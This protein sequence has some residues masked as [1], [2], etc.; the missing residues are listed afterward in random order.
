M[1]ILSWGK[2]RIFLGKRGTSDE[3]P[4]SWIEVPTPVENSTTLTPTKGTKT[5][6]KIE[7]GDNEAVRYAKNTYAL[8][9]QI[10]GAKDREKPVEDDDG[11]IEG[12]YSVKVMPEDPTAPGI[13][14]K[15]ST[16]SMSPSFSTADGIIWEYTADALK[17][18]EGNSVVFEVVTDPT[19]A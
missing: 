17:P 6:A 13:T 14:I 16:L 3:E 7:G 8:V 9:F 4:S 12:E 5:E 1:A 10:R 2:C 19:K 11:V 15:K 18:D